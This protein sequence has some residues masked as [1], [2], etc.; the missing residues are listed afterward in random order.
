MPVLGAN[1]LDRFR[2]KLAGRR[3]LLPAP[4]TKCSGESVNLA[5]GRRRHKHIE[6]SNPLR[7]CLGSVPNSRSR[8]SASALPRTCYDIKAPQRTGA[9]QFG[10]FN[11]LETDTF[12][13]TSFEL[14]CVPSEKNGFVPVS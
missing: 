1:P 10:V 13:I 6:A 8:C 2:R 12:T 14:L 7:V 4:L 3:E 11:Q 5:N 9:T